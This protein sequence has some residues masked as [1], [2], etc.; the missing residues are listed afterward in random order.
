MNLIGL[1]VFVFIIVNNCSMKNL[2]DESKPISVNKIPI[3]SNNKNT[4]KTAKSLIEKSQIQVNDIPKVAVYENNEN[5]EKFNK[6]GFTAPKKIEKQKNKYHFEGFVSLD[7]ANPPSWLFGRIDR[8]INSDNNYIFGIG[9]GYK[10]KNR[11]VFYDSE[12]MARLQL[13]YLTKK[14]KTVLISEVEKEILRFSDLD[15]QQ[16]A[17]M[18]ILIELL[19]ATILSKSK[20][21][22][23][24]EHP[25]RLKNFALAS[26]NLGLIESEISNQK[27]ISKKVINLF[28]EKYHYSLDKSKQKFQ[29]T[30]CFIENGIEYENIDGSYFIY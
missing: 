7:K 4:K 12:N 5:L 25:K 26:I 3:I 28:H 21:V 16:I 20:I 17:K 27:E 9:S 24:W 6:K 13:S 14:F 2:K 11:N 30:F 23:T 1:L 19:S 10:T 8:K 18:K 15:K 22:G 29:Y